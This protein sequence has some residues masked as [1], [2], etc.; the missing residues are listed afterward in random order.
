MKKLMAIV[1]ILAV[2]VA[3]Q[4]TLSQ[5]SQMPTGAM[6]TEWYIA[7]DLGDLPGFERVPMTNMTAYRTYDE[8][9]QM[10][11]DARVLGVSKYYASADMS[12]DTVIETMRASIVGIAPIEQG[13]VYTCHTNR[14]RD[15]VSIDGNKVNVQI[16]CVAGRIVV[17]T[18]MLLGGY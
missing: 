8:Q 13:N 9:A 16:A 7:T 3:I 17:G 2:A 10:P 15:S 4:C 5:T 11:S 14:L 1:A 6:Y 12:L 18:P